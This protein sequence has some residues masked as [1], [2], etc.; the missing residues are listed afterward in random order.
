MSKN[1]KIIA[2]SCL[3]FF[4]CVATLEIDIFDYDNTF[5]DNYDSYVKIES[6]VTHRLHNVE[7]DRLA[8]PEII[9]LTYD[10]LFIIADFFP[11]EPRSF[12]HFYRPKLFLINSS[13]LI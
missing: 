9:L 3:C 5:F 2:A 10:D 11:G 8:S 7:F 1:S 6:K 4:F 13:F 12:N